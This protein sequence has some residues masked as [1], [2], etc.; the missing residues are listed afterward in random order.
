MSNTLL[1][2]KALQPKALCTLS[3]HLVQGFESLDLRCV[4]LRYFRTGFPRKRLSFEVTHCT[5]ERRAPNEVNK[6]VTSVATRALI[7]W[8]MNSIVGALESE[9]VQES[10]QLRL[11][12][13][14]WDVP[15]HQ[16][17]GPGDLGT[18][19]LL[20]DASVLSESPPGRGVHVVSDSPQ[21]APN[22]P[23]SHTLDKCGNTGSCRRPTS[24]DRHL[25]CANPGWCC[26][27]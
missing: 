8:K 12:E 1:F 2:K 15:Q 16:S 13:T 4:H 10:E 26:A 25:R 7:D 9:S 17:G 6:S 19:V 14:V 23:N 3:N 27:R 24:S 20:V 5:T 22:L 11:S 21:Q 18:G